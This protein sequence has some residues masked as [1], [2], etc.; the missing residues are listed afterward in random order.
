MVGAAGHGWSVEWAGADMSENKYLANNGDAVLTLQFTALSPQTT[1]NNSP[2]Y[3]IRKYAGDANATDLRI[4]PTN[5]VV[6]IF[7]INGAI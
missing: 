2:L 6:K 7:K 1:W 5:G 4:T 3:V